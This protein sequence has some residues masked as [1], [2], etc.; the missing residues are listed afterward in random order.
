MMEGEKKGSK[1]KGSG[2][3]FVLGLTP[4]AI[5]WHPAGSIAIRERVF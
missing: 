3:V 4:E 1:K 2:A 5:I